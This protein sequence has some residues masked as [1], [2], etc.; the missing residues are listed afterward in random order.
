[1]KDITAAEALRANKTKLLTIFERYRVTNP[2]LFGSVARGDA[3]G[4][5]DIDIL[6]SKLGPMDYAT[7][8]ALRREVTETLGWPTHLVFE[9]ALKPDIRDEIQ[10]NLRPL[11]E[12]KHDG[13]FC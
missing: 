13:G 4:Q 7:I 10:R 8:G 6:V 2:R 5:S 12:E 11:F 1:M 3:D 9:S